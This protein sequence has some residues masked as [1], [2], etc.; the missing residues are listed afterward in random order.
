M[1]P[2]LVNKRPSKTLGPAAAH[3]SSVLHLSLYRE[4]FSAIA[5]GTK[6]IEYR[7]QSTHWKSRIEGKRYDAVLFRN[8]YAPNAP[9]MLVQ[10]LGVRRYGKGRDAYYA[11]RRGKVLKI[12]RWHPHKPSRQSRPHE[13][14]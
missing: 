5:D 4:H 1:L 6:P 12:V 9:E 2:R 14:G 10:F 13:K 3:H 11:I 8:G 7:P